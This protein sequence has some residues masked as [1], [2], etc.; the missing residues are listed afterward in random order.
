MMNPGGGYGPPPQ[1]PG[2][3][4]PPPRLRGDMNGFAPRNPAPVNVPP[5]ELKLIFNRDEMAYLF[6]FDGVLVTQLCQQVFLN[7]PGRV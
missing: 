5:V 1:N 7:K 2:F 3:G 4:G 6:G